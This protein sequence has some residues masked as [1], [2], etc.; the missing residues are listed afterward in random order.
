MVRAREE[1]RQE[2]REDEREEQAAAALRSRMVRRIADA[3]EL[4]DPAWRAAFEQ[5]PRHLFVPAYH[6]PRPDG[7][8]YGRISR[9]DP[10]S[11]RR[12]RWLTGVY[13]D[14]PLITV[15]R[16][17]QPVSS[18]SQPSLM[19]LMLEG[20]DVRDGQTV[21][22]IGTGTGYNAALLAHRL[23]P[24]AVT[25]VDVD[26]ETTGAARAHLA[27]AGIAGVSVR[28]ADG[29][30]G[31]PERAPY[32]RIVATCEPAFVPPEWL[33]Q[34]RPGGLILAPLAG[35]LV[36]LRVTGPTHAEGRFLDTAAYFVPL[37]TPGAG[38]VR[39][40]GPAAEH[41]RRTTVPPGVLAD[42]SFRFVVTLAAGEV[43]IR[44]I[45]GG[46]GAQVTSADG[47]AAR[48][49]RDGTVLVTGARDLWTVVER[50][51]DLWTGAHRPGRGRFGFTVDGPRQWAWLDSPD[52]PVVREVIPA[53]A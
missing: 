27:A 20:L 50:S 9:S 2:K 6:R 33:R 43:D 30:A 23:G 10:D 47:A 16:E 15:V 40:R 42:D 37:R 1:K 19:A 51:H 38:R 17:G 7:T 13:A 22:E 46:R 3:G 45:P 48:A 49:D 39:P 41:L 28:T 25:T 31:C 53:A 34:C 5:V 18:S 4:T 8:G 29:T 52:G 11:R 26:P 36:A 44:W 24:G 35:G 32:D 14:Q 21:L 12:S